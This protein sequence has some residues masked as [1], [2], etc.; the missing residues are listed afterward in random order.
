[1][2]QNTVAPRLLTKSQAAAYCGLSVSTFSGVCPVRAIALGEGVRMHRYDVRD[3]DTWI[4]SFKRGESTGESV[5]RAALDRLSSPTD[6]DDRHVKVLRFMRDHPECET[7]AEIP[8]A[9]EATLV[10]LSG[11]SMVRE[12]TKDAKGKR[13]FTLTKDGK[14]EMRKIEAW[15][16]EGRR[17]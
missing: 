8:G 16:L 13:R 17:R 6:L 7:A 12:I 3:L 14:A 10:M 2:T 1:M 15:E 11:K 9:G 5:L 4:D